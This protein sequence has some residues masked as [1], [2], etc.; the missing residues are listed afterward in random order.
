MATKFLVAN[1]GTNVADEFCPDG[2]LVI[3]NFPSGPMN[4]FIGVKTHKPCLSAKVAEVNANLSRVLEDSVKYYP[5][6]PRPYIK[7]YIVETAVAADGLKVG[8][9]VKIVSD[10]DT[11]TLVDA[12]GNTIQLWDS[13]P[14]L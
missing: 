4:T 5:G 8:T 2:E 11:A 12:D 14:A 6:L 10:Y 1:S 13:Q 3:P 9:N 7:A